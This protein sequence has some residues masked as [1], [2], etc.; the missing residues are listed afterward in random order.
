MVVQSGTIDRR[1]R[2]QFL[3]TGEEKQKGRFEP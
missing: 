1:I 3:W 2:G